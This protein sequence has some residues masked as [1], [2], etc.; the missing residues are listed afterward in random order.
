[1][2]VYE[3]GICGAYHPRNWNGDC[4]EDLYRLPSPDNLIPTTLR[5]WVDPEHDVF[6]V[7]FDGGM[8]AAGC[9]VTCYQ[10]IGQHSEGC[11]SVILAR[12]RPVNPSLGGEGRAEDVRALVKELRDIGYNPLIVLRRPKVEGLIQPEIVEMPT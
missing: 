11:W 7:M 4:R 9:D 3:C 1:M 12:S 5:R 2:Q 6:A 8:H 10:H